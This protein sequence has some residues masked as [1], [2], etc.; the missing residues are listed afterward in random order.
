MSKKNLR[1]PK[2]KKR[3]NPDNLLTTSGLAEVSGTRYS[4]IKYYSQI[5]I[6]PFEQAGERLVRRYNKKEALKRLKEIESLKSK[7][8]TIEEIIDRFKKTTK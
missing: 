4:T 2:I 1:N 6:L 8:L 3:E 5:G 7:R